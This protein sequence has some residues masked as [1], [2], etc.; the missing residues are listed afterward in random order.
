LTIVPV[1][2]PARSEARNAV[3]AG[4]S[5]LRRIPPIDVGMARMITGV[6]LVGWAFGLVLVVLGTRA[7]VKGREAR[8]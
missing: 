1:T 6:L 8:R 4:R 2:S 3:H 7:I 5:S